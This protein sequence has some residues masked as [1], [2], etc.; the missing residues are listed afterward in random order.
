LEPKDAAIFAEFARNK[1]KEIA[2]IAKEIDEDY[3]GK[4]EP[5]H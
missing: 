5:R 2:A 3:Q 1:H 4:S